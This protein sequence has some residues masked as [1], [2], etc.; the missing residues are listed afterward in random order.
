MEKLELFINSDIFIYEE[1]NRIINQAVEL[2]V[3]TQ[4]AYPWSKVY[5]DAPLFIRKIEREDNKTTIHYDFLQLEY[6]TGIPFTDDASIEN[7]IQC[8][9]VML[10]LHV[11][12]KVIAERM[13]KLEP[14]AMRLDVREGK[15]NCIV[16]NDSYN[17]DINSIK[18]ALDFQQQRK[19]D[20]ELKK[21][22]ILSDILQTGM[23]PKS[24]YKRISEL[25]EEKKIE[26]LIGIGSD[27][28][29]NAKVF[30]VPESHFFRTT[31]EYLESGVVES[32]R[33]EL[34]LLK[35]ARKYHFEQISEQLE[36][37][38][39]ETVLEVDLDAVVHNYN[40]YKS[41]LSPDT[42]LIC[43]V[44][45][46]G[47]GAGSLEIAKTLQYHRCDYFAVAVAE[48]G[49]LLRDE[50]ISAPI[51]VLNPEVN[52]FEELFSR[53]LEPEIYNF[54]ILNAF[55]KEAERRGYTN[56]PIHLKIDTGMH[57][58][59]FLPTQLSELTRTLKSQKGLRV[60][61]IFSHLSASESWLFDEFTNSQISELNKA[62][63][64][65]NEELGYP[66]YKHI[67]NSAGI[68]R[69][70]KAQWDM[71]RLGIGLYGVSAGGI[72]GLK[73]VCTL[74]TTILQIKEIARHETVGYG[75]KETLERDVRIATIRI[76]YADGLNRRLGNRNSFVLINGQRAPI[77]GDI[78]MD[79]CMV[80]VTDIEAREGDSVIVFG[81][82][83]SVVDLA[84]NI[85]TIP[86]EILTAISPRV[87][88]VYVKE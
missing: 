38:I 27:I 80:D 10:Y 19:S 4:K 55:V 56:Y 41:M 70:E 66:L 37:R 60:K 11:D 87:K 22:L 33:N 88:R 29:E 12:P 58:L 45:A 61:S 71:V 67:L 1:D 51:I 44:K 40:F 78:C 18:I 6:Q 3:L 52:G 84:K 34:I 35:G 49:I 20:K 14:V 65:I 57:R 77:V 36:Q 30:T 9:A 17:S 86:Y 8:L 74:K 73:N 48:E 68:E 79:L 53:N 15:S 2:M 46:N 13:I 85:D 47:Y 59:G 81:E 5:N 72:K 54:R 50:G 63:T 76:G 83:L 42:R 28:F 43:M 64:F 82:G 21:T 16:I 25:V 32:H 62:H 31:D 39:H 7:A 75:R 24:L 69:F 23:I 26:K